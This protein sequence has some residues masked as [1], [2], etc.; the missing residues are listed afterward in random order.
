MTDVEVAMS[1]QPDAQHDGPCCSSCLED[2]EFD[3]VYSLW[4]KCCC[5]ADERVTDE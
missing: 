1:D 5:R 3:S 4:P 2:E